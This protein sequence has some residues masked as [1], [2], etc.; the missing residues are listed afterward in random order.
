MKMKKLIVALL[1]ATLCMVAPAAALD[2]DMLPFST[3]VWIDPIYEPGLECGTYFD[4]YL[5]TSE[6]EMGVAYPGWCVNTG[7]S[8]I[9]D[10]VYSA[11][12]STTIGISE[13][14]NKIN[15]ILNHKGE[16][17]S[18]E[19][20]VAIWIILDQTIPTRHQG[21]NTL[22]AQQLAE[23]ADSMYVPTCYPEIGAVLV[24][25]NDRVGQDAIIEIPMPACPPPVPEF[26]TMMIPVFLVGS[27]MV[28]AIVL[29]KE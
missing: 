5:P 9:R 17:T 19:V 12:L 4:L 24:V 23:H 27:L 6:E 29:K 21:W 18:G 11:D 16:A 22:V 1:V 25:P 13:K 20:Q 14:Y 15:W 10:Q 3:D 8:A 26:P 2:W 28:A 7:P